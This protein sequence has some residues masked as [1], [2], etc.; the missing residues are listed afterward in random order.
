MKKKFTKE[1][2][3]GTISL[4]ILALLD[5]ADRPMYGYEIVKAM[6]KL[7][8]EGE[9][10]IKQGTLYPVLRALHKNGLLDSKVEPSVSGPP[11]RYYTTS[12]Q[13]SEQLLEWQAIW[14][15]TR[16][17]VDRV[18]DGDADITEEMS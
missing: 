12:G 5:Q 9:P 15:R 7:S 3:S 4:V 17:F 2:N 14:R 10:A 1:I 8:P 11:R 18:L 16:D 13:G 6:E